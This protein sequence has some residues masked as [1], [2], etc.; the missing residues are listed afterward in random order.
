MVKKC[1]F[2]ETCENY[3]KCVY[4]VNI[5]REGGER[6]RKSSRVRESH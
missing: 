1:F 2:K 5:P 6:L 3:G 4:R